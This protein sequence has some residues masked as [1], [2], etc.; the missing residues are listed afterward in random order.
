MLTEEKFGPAYAG[1]NCPYCHEPVSVTTVI[2]REIY[3]CLS[4]RCSYSW[5]GDPEEYGPEWINVG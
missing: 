1:A 3:Y 4:A 2:G 5:W